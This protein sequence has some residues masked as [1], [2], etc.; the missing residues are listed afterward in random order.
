M[1]DVQVKT[2]EPETVAYIAM[3]G[4]YD[5]IPMAMGKLYGWVAQHQLEPVGM[6]SGVYLNDPEEVS[7]DEALWKLRAPI[8]GDRESMAP[9][10]AGCGIEQV[11]PHLV[12]SAMHHGPYDTIAHTY[13]ELGDWV[14]DNGY[15]VVGPPEEFYL[16]DPDTTPPE[17]YL[18]EVHFTVAKD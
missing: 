7:Q 1:I 2:T 5:Q 18:T 12:A 9:D 4:P 8:S 15:T 16:S 3:R 17:E 11:A 10:E 13:H 6:P 14:I